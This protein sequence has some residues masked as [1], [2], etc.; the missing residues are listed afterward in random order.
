MSTTTTHL[1]QR[2]ESVTG[3]LAGVEAGLSVFGEGSLPATIRRIVTELRDIT[4]EME[5]AE[6]SGGK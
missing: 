3:Q 6:T 2:L 1:R 5:V 4:S